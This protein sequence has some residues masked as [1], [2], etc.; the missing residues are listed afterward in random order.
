MNPSRNLRREHATQSPA[1]E[2][3]REAAAAL[4]LLNRQRE[5]AC[6]I[7]GKVLT[8]SR[9]Y[10]GHMAAHSRKKRKVEQDYA[11]AEFSSGFF[12]NLP[13]AENIEK[14]C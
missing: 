1:S 5:F 12:L 7:C 8:T 3:E 14:S 4:L 9:G 2:E 13:P 11:R 10:G 6:E